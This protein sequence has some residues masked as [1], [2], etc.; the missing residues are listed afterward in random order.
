MPPKKSWWAGPFGQAVLG[1]VGS[2]VVAAVGYIA[3]QT[4]ENAYD[5]QRLEEKQG[6][7]AK[8]VAAVRQSL[9]KLSLIRDP[10]LAEILGSLVVDEPTAKGIEAFR[11][12]DVKLAVRTWEDAARGGSEDALMALSAAGFDA[13]LDRLEVTGAKLD[14]KPFWEQVE[15]LP[16][17]PAP[18]K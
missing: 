14:R 13:A 16:Q 5:I 15:E 4:R 7:V 2:L 1:I 10:K 9:L 12:G 6:E 18:E 3:W 11:G 8:S 17:Q